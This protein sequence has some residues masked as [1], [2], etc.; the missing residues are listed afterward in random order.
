MGR[1]QCDTRPYPRE[2]EEEYLDV[3]SV[4]ASHKCNICSVPRLLVDSSLVGASIPPYGAE[5]MSL[6]SLTVQ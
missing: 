1:R 2:S 4:A 6:Y 5:E 3:R